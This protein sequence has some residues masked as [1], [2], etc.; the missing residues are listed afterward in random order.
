MRASRKRKLWGWCGFMVRYAPEAT[1]EDQLR[2]ALEV[3]GFPP[4][5][6]R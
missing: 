1:T 5:V 2:D 3:A 6:P 4:N